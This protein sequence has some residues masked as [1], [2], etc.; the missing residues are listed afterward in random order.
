MSLCCGDGGS[1][2]V[3]SKKSKQH[4]SDRT[5][6][7]RGPH[8]GHTG[9]ARGLNR[10]RTGASWN[11]TGI[12]SLF[13]VYCDVLSVLSFSICL[14]EHY[15]RYLHN[16]FCT[17]CAPL[18][19]RTLITYSRRFRSKRCESNRKRCQRI[20]SRQPCIKRCTKFT[21]LGFGGQ[22]AVRV[23]G[24]QVHAARRIRCLPRGAGRLIA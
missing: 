6:L 11:Y 12:W 20:S 4:V 14:A 7:Q 22:G 1:R 10:G 17:P 9:A 23:F 18:S 8:E 15:C 16:T 2:V 5:G 3:L 24:A 19:Q 21:K 13:V